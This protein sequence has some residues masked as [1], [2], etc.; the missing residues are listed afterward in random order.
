M[1]FIL[2]DMEVVIEVKGSNRVH[3][4]DLRG[5]RALREEHTVRHALVVSLE[6]KRRT[7]ED[8]IDIYPWKDFLEA[9]WSGTFGV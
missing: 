4:G 5:L 6:Q 1:D 9:L 7:T 8:R 3:D 2:N